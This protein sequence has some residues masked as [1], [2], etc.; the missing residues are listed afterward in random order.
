MNFVESRLIGI[1]IDETGREA[2][3][4]LIGTDGVKFVLELHGI[5]RLLITEMRQQ[6]VVEDML[7][8]GAGDNSDE[9]REAAFELMTGGAPQHCSQ[10]LATVVEEV[11]ARVGR[12]ELSMVE[13]RAIFG[14][15]VL[16][17]F[18]SMTIRAG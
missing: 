17:S 12:G 8:W 10:A 18:T 11:V 7:Q 15:Q 6:N 16:A 2:A 5:E 9:L 1:Q 4:S 3:L 13:I 14:A